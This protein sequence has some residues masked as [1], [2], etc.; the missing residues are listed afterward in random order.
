[1]TNGIRLI[2]SIKLFGFRYA[3]LFWF[4]WSFSNPIKIFWWKYIV[5]RPLCTYHGYFLCK[6]DCQHEK[7]TGRK[8]IYKYSKEN[9]ARIQKESNTVRG[10]KDGVCVYC[11]E[12]RGTEKIDDP[13]W[14]TLEKWLVCKTCEKVLELQREATFPLLSQKRTLEISD[15]LKQIS[16]DTGKPIMMAEISKDVNG[17]F[18]T[19]SVK[20]TV[21]KDEV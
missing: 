1:M 3:V 19:S 21:E 9:W 17:K 16:D 6:P 7:I 13:N 2:D 10:S 14:D 18:N 5:A 4:A 8:N 20:Y 12:E 11:G 15:E